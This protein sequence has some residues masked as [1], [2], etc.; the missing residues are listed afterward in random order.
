MNTQPLRIG[1]SDRLLIGVT[2]GLVVVVGFFAGLLALTVGGVL[3][4]TVGVKLW[5]FERQRSKDVID[6]EYR[7]LRE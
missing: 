2:A 1:W 4:L 3:A 7:V 5:W 6:A